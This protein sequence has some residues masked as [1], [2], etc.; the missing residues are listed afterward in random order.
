MVLLKRKKFNFNILKS[1]LYQLFFLLL[2]AGL[3]VIQMAYAAVEFDYGSEEFQEIVSKLYMQ[4]H[5]DHDLSTCS[6]KATYYKEVADMMQQGKTN[7][8]IINYY[9]EQYGEAALK[10]P[11]TEGFSLMAWLAPFAVLL[12]AAVAIFIVV[13][14]WVHKNK[15]HLS[16]TTEQDVTISSVDES[17]RSKIDEERKKYL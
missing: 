4:G 11:S 8:Q 6:I 12:I 17:T 15:L 1:I 14:S 3:L 2:F 10:V 16:T 13:R 5:A 9:V 7:G